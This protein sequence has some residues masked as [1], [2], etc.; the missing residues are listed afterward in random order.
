[1]SKKKK[2][3]TA[4]EPSRS[5]RMTGFTPTIESHAIPDGHRIGKSRI[6]EQLRELPVS[7]QGDGEAPCYTLPKKQGNYWRLV[8]NRNGMTVTIRNKKL[9][10]GLESDADLVCLWRQS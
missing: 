2:A 7:A 6:L 8:A 10:T 9:V 4:T 3:M 5:P 1:M